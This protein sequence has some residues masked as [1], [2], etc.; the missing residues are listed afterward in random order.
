MTSRALFA[1]V[2]A[3]GSVLAHEADPTYDVNVYGVR[4]GLDDGVA[5]SVSPDVVM[6]VRSFCRL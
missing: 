2:V 6:Y 5:I 4:M 1:L 3:L